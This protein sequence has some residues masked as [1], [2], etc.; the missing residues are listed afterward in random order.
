MTVMGMTG[1]GSSSSSLTTSLI[2]VNPPHIATHTP[3]CLIAATTALSSTISLPFACHL[4]VSLF[5]A[6]HHSH[7]LAGAAVVACMHAIAHTCP[8]LLAAQSV[9]CCNSSCAPRCMHPVV[10]RRSRSHCEPVG[11]RDCAL[12]LPAAA[13][14]GWGLPKKVWNIG[15]VS[16][17]I[18]HPGCSFLSLL[19]SVPSPTLMVTAYRP[20]P[21]LS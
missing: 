21:L 1:R 19:L 5:H 13:A 17:T 14:S 3:L 2:I 20:L 8:N 7:T 12:L 16:T 18:S 10:R 15:M 4:L 9:P 11:E 6:S